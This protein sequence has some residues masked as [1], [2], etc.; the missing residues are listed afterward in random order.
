MKT[1]HAA[2]CV[3]RRKQG[4]YMG[5][6]WPVFGQFRPVL[7][8]YFETVLLRLGYM[9]FQASVAPLS[10]CASLSLQSTLPVKWP[11]KWRHIRGGRKVVDQVSCHVIGDLVCRRGCSVLVLY[12]CR[13]TRAIGFWPYFDFPSF[14]FLCFFYIKLSVERKDVLPTWYVPNSFW[15]ANQY[16]CMCLVFFTW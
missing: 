14:F 6:K 4:G 3:W 8:L 1:R 13:V 7:C 12:F 16:M 10:C 15:W 9:H 11:W 5:C 2:W